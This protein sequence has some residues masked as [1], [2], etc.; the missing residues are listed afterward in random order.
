MKI[1]YS[2]ESIKE[3]LKETNSSKIVLVSSNYLISNCQWAISEI[4][5]MSP[6][7][8]KIVRIPNG[9]KAKE[10]TVLE[11]L[12]KEFVKAGL[13]RKSLVVALGG[14]SVTDLVGFAASIYQRGVRYINIP[15]TLLAQV[16]GS[17]GSKTAINFLNCKNQIGSLHNPIAVIMDNRFLKTLKRDQI[18]DGLGE[19]IKAGFI[20]DPKI[21]KL[22]E[23]HNIKIIDSP[24]IK[25]LISRSIKVK[26]YFVEKD[27]QDN[28]VRQLLNFG[29]TVGHALELKY[30]LSH[31][32]AVLIGMVEELKIAEKLKETKTEVRYFL[33]KLLNNLGIEL[34]QLKIDWK[35]ILR[36]KKI[37]G[38]E[39][40]FPIIKKIGESKIIKIKVDKLKKYIK[41]KC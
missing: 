40:D 28:G 20:K 29:H 24:S 13:D 3:V 39:I 10:W 16:D 2:L 6:L 31:G 36:D 30:G 17:I 21:L 11:K 37:V 35:Y 19:I 34:K 8:I 32:E 22:I 33:E 14:G 9:E 1:Y 12:L 27:P 5:K 4:I 18:I 7:E 26:Q 15:T 25:E 38:N 23:A 41:N